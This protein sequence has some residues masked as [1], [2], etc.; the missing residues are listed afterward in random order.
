MS[1]YSQFQDP[2]PDYDEVMANEK[3]FPI[4]QSTLTGGGN[5]SALNDPHI[6]KSTL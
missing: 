1:I 5:R 6:H 4:E 3:L 2:P